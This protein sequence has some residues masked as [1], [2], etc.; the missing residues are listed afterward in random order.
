MS[1]GDLY[2]LKEIL[3]HKTVLMTQR[4]A[5]LSQANKR[6]SAKVMDAFGTLSPVSQNPSAQP[7]SSNQLV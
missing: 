6:E 2:T 7:V 3:G 1:G 4:Y 5:H